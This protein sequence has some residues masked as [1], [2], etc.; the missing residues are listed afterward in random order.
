MLAFPRLYF[1][2]LDDAPG[3]GFP[4]AGATSTGAIAPKSKG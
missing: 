3:A 1:L 2:W 4:Q